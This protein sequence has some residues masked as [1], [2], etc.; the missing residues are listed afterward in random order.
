M[1][2][3][4]ETANGRVL[5]L[6]I[7]SL[8]VL[9]SI[10]AFGQEPPLSRLATRN[11]DRATTEAVRKGGLREAA[12]L[13]GTFVTT[14]NPFVWDQYDVGSLAAKSKII[15]IGTPTTSMCRLSSDGTY[16]TTDYNV[17]LEQVLKGD[18][19]L[20]ANPSQTTS[21]SL[22]VKL[23]GGYVKFEDGTSAVMLTPG[24]K[25]MEIGKRYV[26]F[27]SDRDKTRPGDLILTGGPQGLFEITGDSKIQPHGRDIDKV[28]QYK[29]ADAQAFFQ[30]I[31]ESIKK[32]TS[33]SCCSR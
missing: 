31:R 11:G 19:R 21:T 4:R 12:K 14:G 16:I 5:I 26:L 10:K 27:L 33:D 20:T 29:D 7:V 32:P 13:R 25:K 22:T 1:T 24:F 8:A 9:A 3:K 17:Q 28:K 23:L 15:V 18:L 30:T 2:N 6:V